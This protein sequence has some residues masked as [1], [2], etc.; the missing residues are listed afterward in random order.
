MTPTVTTTTSNNQGQ[1][2]GAAAYNFTKSLT[3]G[4]R[5]ADVTAL[6]QFLSD[7]KF[8]TGPV[9]GYFGQLTKT[10][11]IAFQ[12]ARGIAQ[13]GNVG[14][15]TRAELNKGIIA[16]TPTTTQPASSG[17]TATQGAAILGLLQSFN[18]DAS[19]IA[20]VKASLGLI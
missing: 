7:N 16:T 17:L 5:G 15:L 1:V 13:V 3:V 9:T 19:V 20:N 2:L 6:Q 10:A 11:V 14:P 18:A 8:Y 12:K 4:S